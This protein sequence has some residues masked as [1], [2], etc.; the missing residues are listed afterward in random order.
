MPVSALTPDTAANLVAAAL[1]SAGLGDLTFTRA[2]WPKYALKDLTETKAHV[3]AVWPARMDPHDDAGTA[4]E[5]PLAVTIDAQCEKGEDAK[6]AALTDLLEQIGAFLANTNIEGLGYPVEPLVIDRNEE[7]L[8]KG[9]FCGGVG[10]VYRRYRDAED[11][12]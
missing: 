1:T 7:L 10:L 9:Q 2:R 8:D 12:L 4:T 11:G 5:T 6:A 3:V